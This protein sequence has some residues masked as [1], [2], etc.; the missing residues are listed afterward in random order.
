VIDTGNPVTA[1]QDQ[2]EVGLT[3]FALS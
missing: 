2:G 3:A 1:Q